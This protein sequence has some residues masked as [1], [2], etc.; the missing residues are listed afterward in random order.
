MTGAAGGSDATGID[1]RRIGA[2]LL[3]AC[4]LPAFASPAAAPDDDPT[5]PTMPTTDPARPAELYLEVSLNGVKTGQVVPFQQSPKGLRASVQNLRE[6]GLDPKMLGLDGQDEFALDAVADLTYQF[7]PA[8]QTIDLVLGDALRRPLQLNARST[9]PSGAG[10]ADPGLLLNYDLYGQSGRTIRVAALNELRLF[11]PYGVLSSS[12][13][14]VLKGAGQR[15]IR[16]DTSWSWSDPATLQSVQVGDFIAPALGWTRALRMAGVEWRRNFELRPD[17]LTYPLASIGSSAVVPSSVSLYV[18]G[19]EQ[20]RTEVPGG[21]FVI[22]QVAGLNGAGQATVVTRDALGRQV[23]TSLPLYVDTRLLASGLSDFAVSAGVLRRAYGLR[24]FRYAGSPALTGSLRH[25][26]SDALTVEAHVEAGAALLNGGAGAMLRIGKAGGVLTGSLAGSAGDG[27][28][29]NGVAPRGAQA[30]LG[31]QYIAPRFALDV[32]S[33]RASA[34]YADLGTG[35]G[36]PVIRVNDRASLSLNLQGAG[37]ASVSLV[38]YRIPGQEAVRLAALAW[39]RSLGRGAYLSVSAFQDL[40]KPEGRGVSATLSIALGERTSASAGHS[41]QGGVATNSLSATRAPEFGGGWGWGV[42]GA[43][44]GAFDIAQAQVQYLGSAGQFSATALRAGDNNSGSLGMSGSLVAMDGAVL[45]ARHVGRGFA[46]VST[47]LADVPVS[48]EN[49]PLGRTGGDGRLLVPDLMP[50]TGNRI[51]IDAG[52]LPADMRIERTILSV[53]PLAGAGVVAGFK[54]ERYRA[55]T[56]IVHEPDG[57]AVAV[58]T[59][60]RLL[61]VPAAPL[62][63]VGYDGVVFLDGLQDNND[64]VV[65]EGAG[66]CTLHVTYQ[67]G[68]AG[69]LPVIGP[70]RCLPAKETR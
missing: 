39:S 47:G 15:F 18:N 53:V 67:P 70:L 69:Q 16:Y 30:S 23:A 1:L 19:N 58:G 64:V 32:Q 63:V 13:N 44:T 40:G 41:R 52:N 11:G 54:V 61:N 27:D 9:R 17:L 43:R 57:K 68:T 33:V 21:P 29:A 38:H 7:D 49:R 14:A 8:L 36:A 4:S 48:H 28:R 65:G 22:D 59:P 56:V 34:G 26:W 50:Y 55:A 10:S 42:Q 35:E 3:L 12:G 25:G 62:S 2:V 20:Y 31:Y 60:V 51:A 24:S 37:S 66:A 45:A 6:L 5:L 46:L